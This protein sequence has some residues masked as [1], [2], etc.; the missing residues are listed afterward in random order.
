VKVDGRGKE[1]GVVQL[2]DGKF[3][4]DDPVLGLI[5]VAG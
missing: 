1:P 4:A 2:A 3:Q 5:A